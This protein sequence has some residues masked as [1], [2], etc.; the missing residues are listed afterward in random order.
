MPNLDPL[1]YTQVFYS[2]GFSAEVFTQQ[3]DRIHRLGQE[4]VCEYY[5][6]FTSSPVEERIREAI[7]DKIQLRAD[8]LVDVIG[9]VLSQ[10]DPAEASTIQG[11]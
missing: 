7:D 5:R 1:V 3:Q 8:M 6:L 9:T 2:I 4:R 11:T 10:S